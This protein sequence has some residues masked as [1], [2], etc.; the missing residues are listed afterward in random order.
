MRLTRHLEDWCH[1]CGNRQPEIVD[2]WY[3]RHAEH[4]GPNDS[5]IRI[6]RDCGERIAQVASRTLVAVS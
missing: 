5:Y 3:P 1:I 2:V 4:G 6:C